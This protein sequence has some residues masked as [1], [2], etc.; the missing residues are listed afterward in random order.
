MARDCTHFHQVDAAR[1]GTVLDAFGAG[2]KRALAEVDLST[3][4]Y[5][6]MGGACKADW[7]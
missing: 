2:A 4:M 5:S 6:L 3:T 1:A 7:A